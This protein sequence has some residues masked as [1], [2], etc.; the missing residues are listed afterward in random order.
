MF[1][2]AFMFFLIII[3]TVFAG[4]K[5]AESDMPWTATIR[6]PETQGWQLVLDKFSYW[7]VLTVVLIVVAYGRG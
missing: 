1:I 2:A 4:E 7:L 5:R 3:M 6:P